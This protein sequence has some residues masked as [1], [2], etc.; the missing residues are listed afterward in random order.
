MVIG[1]FTV[2][3]RDWHERV[4]SRPLKSWSAVKAD[5]NGTATIIIAIGPAESDGG[6]IELLVFSPDATCEVS[7]R[8]DYDGPDGLPGGVAASGALAPGGLESL[9]P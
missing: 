6:S 7:A 3:T 5:A 1:D 9:N 2:D 8:V 4:S